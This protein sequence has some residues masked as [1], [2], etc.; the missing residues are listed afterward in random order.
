MFTYTV[1]RK[2]EAGQELGPNSHQDLWV[3]WDVEANNINEAVEHVADI[4]ADYIVYQ[5]DPIYITVAPVTEL[6]VTD[7]NGQ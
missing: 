5:A 1:M 2:A 7:S 3:A 4:P 6:K